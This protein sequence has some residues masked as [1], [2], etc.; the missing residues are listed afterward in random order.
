MKTKFVRQARWL[1]CALEMPWVPVRVADRTAIGC[2]ENEVG[3]LLAGDVHGKIVYEWCDE[4][5]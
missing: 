3:R 2:F 4:R 5:H 1:C